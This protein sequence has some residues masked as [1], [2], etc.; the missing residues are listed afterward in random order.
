MLS[1]PS[2][3]KPKQQIRTRKT[4]QSK[5]TASTQP[6]ELSPDERAEIA[7]KLAAQEQRRR[8]PSI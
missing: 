1:K 8:P 3:K 7:L 4:A 5:E 2:P 6:E